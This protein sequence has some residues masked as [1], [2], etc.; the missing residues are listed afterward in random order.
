MDD[1]RSWMELALDEA[2]NCGDDVPVG[3]IILKD[4]KVL[5]RGRNQREAQAD[6][7]GHAEIIAMREA[8]KILGTW[9]LHGT[10]LICTLEPCPMCAEA[11]IQS[12]VGKLVY[13]APDLVYGAV[14]SA[15]NLF[16]KGRTF[17]IPEVVG[18]IME[19]ESRELLKE[20]FRRQRAAR[21]PKHA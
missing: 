4:G 13:G 5:A 8:A 12:R 17:P 9:R 21:E 19:D 15:F 1:F 16:A 11:I 14:G 20:F 6:P 2:R 7:T 10:I 18:G 3:C